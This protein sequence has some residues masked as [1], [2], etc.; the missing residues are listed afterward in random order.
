MAGLEWLPANEAID[1]IAYE[2]IGKLD[3]LGMKKRML[4]SNYGPKPLHQL[5]PRPAT[6]VTFK[7]IQFGDR[8]THRS[9]LNEHLQ[10]RPLS[11]MN[12]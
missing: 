1:K 2:D 5:C 8:F 4:N 9:Y 10:I 7:D 6:Q 12:A 11:T 3:P